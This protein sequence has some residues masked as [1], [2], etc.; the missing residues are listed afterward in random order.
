MVGPLFVFDK[1]ERKDERQVI[2]GTLF[3]PARTEA[4]EIE[5]P[6]QQVPNPNQQ[7]KVQDEKMKKGKETNIPSMVKREEML[8]QRA[9]QRPE[10]DGS[11]DEE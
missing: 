4:V 1:I 10:E 3:S 11:Y 8:R 7:K 5:L 2:T 6:L 9:E